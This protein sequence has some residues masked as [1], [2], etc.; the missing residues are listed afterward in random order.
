VKSNLIRSQLQGQ[1]LGPDR[2]QWPRYIA[3][4]WTCRNIA[5][6]VTDMDAILDTPSKKSL[7]TFLIP[8]LNANQQNYVKQYAEL[9][10]H[11]RPH[12]QR[13]TVLICIAHY[14]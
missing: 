10:R 7:W 12:G 3:T 14:Y 8:R 5:Q 6:F 2:L 13:N 1:T 4:R 9:P 11:N